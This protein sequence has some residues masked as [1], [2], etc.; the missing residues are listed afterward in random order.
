MA[1]NEDQRNIVLT[2]FMGTGKSTIGPILAARMGRVYYDMDTAIE[3]RTGLIIPRIFAERSEPFFRAIERGLCH[4]LAL[5]RELV[6]AT[7]GGALI[8]RESREVMVQ[9]GFVVCLMASEETIE[10]RLR[11]TDLRPLA[12]KWRELLAQRMPI[13][14]S[15]PYQVD[16]TGKTPH[17]VVEEILALWHSS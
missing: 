7:G 10:S 4:E 14:Q 6:I 9:S 12:G 2:G 11:E 13:Y 16:T 15:L 8:D 1:T 17:E 5:Q 3:H